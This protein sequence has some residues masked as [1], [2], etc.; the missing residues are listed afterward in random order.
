M[1]KILL[2]I[3]LALNTVAAHAE[4]KRIDFVSDEVALYVDPSTAEKSGPRMVLLWHVAD[5][6]KPQDIQGKPFKSIKFRHE[7]DC[8]KGMFRDMLRSWHKEAMGN[9]ITVSWTHGPWG[10]T[11]PEAGSADEALVN[12][13]CKGR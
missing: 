11:K 7:Y 10:W 13:A 6:A 8:N 12:N 4:W 2:L 3:A 1:K 5:Y 9:S